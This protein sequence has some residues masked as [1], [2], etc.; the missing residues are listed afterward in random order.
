MPI[1]EYQCQK[2]GVVFEKI[3]TAKQEE[4]PLKCAACGA[5]KPRRILSAFSSSKSSE[6]SSPS[7]CG[8]GSS[9]FS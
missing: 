1:Y 6:S 3:Q 7:S 8:G 9:R 5:E 2:C 4:G